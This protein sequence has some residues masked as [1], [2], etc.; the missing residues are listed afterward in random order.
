MKKDIKQQL[1]SLCLNLIEQ[2]ISNAQ[3]AISTAKESANDDRKSSAGDKHET[4]R[5]M[6]QLEQE[7]SGQQLKDVFDLKKSIEKLNLDIQSASAQVGSIVITDKGNFFILAPLGKL[8]VDENIY[9]AISI[10]SPIGDKL[11]GRIK[12]ESFEM[13]GIVYKILEVF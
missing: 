11:K 8:I 4:G 7:K 12:N 10:S 9:Y 1:F 5:A 3:L 13:K 6:A 2:R